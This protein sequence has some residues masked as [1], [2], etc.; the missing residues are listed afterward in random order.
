[1]NRRIFSFVLFSGND[2][3]LQ[4][5]ARSKSDLNLTPNEIAVAEWTYSDGEF[6]DAGTSMSRIQSLD[7]C[8]RRMGQSVDLQG[9]NYFSSFLISSKI[10]PPSC[11][12]FAVVDR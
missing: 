6:A 4:A 12:H 11:L 8:C 2:G 10:I 7:P 5:W 9:T 1:M 3:R